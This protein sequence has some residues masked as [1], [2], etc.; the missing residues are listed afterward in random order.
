[1]SYLSRLILDSRARRVRRDLSDSHQLH[2]TVL[3]AFPEAPEGVSARE[4]FGVLYRIEPL[5]Q[6]PSLVRL[7]VQSKAAPVWSHLPAESLGPAPDARGNPAVR[8]VE[9]EYERIVVGSRLVFRLRANPTKKLSDRTPG[10]NDPL[11]GKR[12]ALLREQE[13]LAWLARKGEVHGFRLLKTELST[14]VPAVQ[15]VTQAAERGRRP[16]GERDQ[17]MRLCFGAVLFDGCLEVTDA[18]RF[19]ATLAGGIGSGKAFGF[20]LLSIAS[21]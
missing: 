21:L 2:R 4:H 13:Q 17:P 10:R 20:G 5:S 8:Q 11:V 9:H 19:R 12:V 6:A 15:V 18:E 14:E 7:L 1:M 3:A 16:G